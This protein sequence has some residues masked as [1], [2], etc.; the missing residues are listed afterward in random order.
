MLATLHLKAEK[1]ARALLADRADPMDR[2]KTVVAADV[3]A[4]VDLVPRVAV[5]A[6]E[7]ASLPP[8]V[9]RAALSKPA[10]IAES[11]ASVDQLPEA[12]QRNI[13]KGETSPAAVIAEEAGLRSVR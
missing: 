11:K 8:A 4:A 13:K 7:A 10:T 6:A 3:A 5:R 12:N 2:A 1:A 9:V